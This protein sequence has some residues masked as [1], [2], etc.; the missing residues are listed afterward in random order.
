MA[1]L[2]LDSLYLRP[3]FKQH[4]GN[5]DILNRGQMTTPELVPLSKLPHHSMAFS[6]NCG[7][8]HSGFEWLLGKIVG[9]STLGLN[10]SYVK[11]ELCKFL[12]YPDISSKTP[13]SL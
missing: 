7:L 4:E 8:V 3:V 9:W 6:K 1:F 12:G 11:N 2:S 10:G 13:K 5:S